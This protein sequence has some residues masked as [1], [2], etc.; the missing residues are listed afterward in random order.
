MKDEQLSFQDYLKQ[1]ENIEVNL[2]AIA[3][4]NFYS[5]HS[6][7]EQNDM[8]RAF[9]LTHPSQIDKIL[10]GI[11]KQYFLM[12]GVELDDPV[13]SAHKVR[14][15]GAPYLCKPSGVPELLKLTIEDQTYSV[16]SEMANIIC[17]LTAL[18]KSDE[19]TGKDE[20]FKNWYI[21]RVASAFI[22]SQQRLRGN[23]LI[24]D[25]VKQTS[26]EAVHLLLEVI[27]DDTDRSAFD[28]NGM[29]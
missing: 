21:T 15:V 7:L 17:N 11:E 1:L 18:K 2:P 23:K 5:T 16:D 10:L 12:F 6:T 14:A 27:R 25:K 22:R 19:Y 20:A 28:F 3:Y 24:P 29:M 9:R 4:G 8:T 13:W 26:V